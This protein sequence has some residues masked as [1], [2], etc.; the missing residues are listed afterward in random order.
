MRRLLTMTMGVAVDGEDFHVFDDTQTHESSW[1]DVYKGMVMLR[2]E[3][4]RQLAEG[5]KCPYNPKYGNQG[6]DFEGGSDDG[7]SEARSAT[8]QI[9]SDLRRDRLP[10]VGNVLLD[11]PHQPH[12]RLT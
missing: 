1:A 8:D 6:A 9:G 11:E 5:R 4:N 7:V 12:E 3:L 2:D 10:P